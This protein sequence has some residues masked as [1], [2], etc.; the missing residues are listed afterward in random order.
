MNDNED[1]SMK[2]DQDPRLNKGA[3]DAGLSG[4]HIPRSDIPAEALRQLGEDGDMA[5]AAHHRRWMEYS[6]AV[7]RVQGDYLR[8]LHAFI[9]P[10]ELPR[11][12][13]LHKRRLKEIKALERKNYGQRDILRK[14][15]TK[16]EH[17]R[18]ET[19]KL[20]ERRGISPNLI[21]NLRQK[22]HARMREE[23]ERYFPIGDA[24]EVP[25]EKA[26]RKLISIRLDDWFVEVTRRKFC[27]KTA[28][29]CAVDADIDF[30]SRRMRHTSTISVRGADDDDRV[31][32]L[33]LVLGAHI[34]RV[35]ADAR[36]LMVM[37]FFKNIDSRANG[38]HE[39]EC[40]LSDYMI[41]GNAV[42]W[43][44]VTRILPL[45]PQHEEK[46]LWL[47]SDSGN[48]LGFEITPPEFGEGT[49][50]AWDFSFANPGE[51]I[52]TTGNFEGAGAAYFPGPFQPG[53]LLGIWTGLWAVNTARLNDTSAYSFLHYDLD[54][55]HTLVLFS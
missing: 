38:H 10:D 43:F 53:H 44:R 19:E 18:R 50:G 16:R 24:T 8:S 46:W 14:L 54:H 40:G 35:P 49:I 12:I 6:E 27:E 52:Y 47:Q 26:L 4:F 34:V 33:S 1:E 31:E 3:A 2:T 5:L 42:C 11:Y 37:A 45:P 22:H 32:A 21:H 39:D 20:R 23:F 25:G 13:K 29:S 41:L 9:G 48:D 15:A 30:N 17:N 36:S 51:T 28:G 55:D 7:R